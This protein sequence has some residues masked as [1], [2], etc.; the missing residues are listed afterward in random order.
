MIN[1]LNGVTCKRGVGV[2]IGLDVFMC[3]EW[4]M[5]NSLNGVSM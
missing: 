5:I 3:K 4:Q 2:C 1:T